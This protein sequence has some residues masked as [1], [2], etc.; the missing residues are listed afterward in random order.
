VRTRVTL[1]LKQSLPGRRLREISDTTAGIT[2]RCPARW[3]VPQLQALR[4]TRASSMTR[5]CPERWAILQL[6]QYAPTAPSR[7]PLAL[8]PTKRAPPPDP[9]GREDRETRGP[10]NPSDREPVKP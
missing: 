6:Q 5:W 4:A 1:L 3:A 9:G 2:R 10:V 7:R 8:N